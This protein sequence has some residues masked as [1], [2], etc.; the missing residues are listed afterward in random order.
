MWFAIQHN[1]C[2]RFQQKIHYFFANTS[3]LGWSEQAATN[4]PIEDEAVEAVLGMNQ[5]HILPA[6]SYC[7]FLFL[8]CPKNFPSYIPPSHLP[9]PSYLHFPHPTSP[10]LFMSPP[11]YLPPPT[12]HLP[13]T[14][15]LLFPTYLLLLTPSPDPRS[16]WSGNRP[17]AG[18]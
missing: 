11:S 12:S 16:C 1:I 5:K 2:A 13:P 6:Q 17:K 3:L 14:S 8:L 9:P 15:P 10:L 18:A 7:F 4:A